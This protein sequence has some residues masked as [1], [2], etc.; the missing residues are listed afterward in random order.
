[1]EIPQKIKNGSALWPSNSTSWDSSKETWNTNWK[2]HK[3]PYIYCS[4]IYNCQDTEAAQVSISRWVAKTTMGHLH[5]GILLGCKKE[6][7]FTLCD[8]MYG[9]VKY[10]AKWNKQ[11]RERQIS[12]IYSYG[13]S[14]EQTELTS[15][16]ETDS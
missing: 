16:I 13:E 10:Y 15:K 6:E 14:N 12:M 9:P 2:E 1:M 5:N 7:N 4:I 3:H 11:V 8:F